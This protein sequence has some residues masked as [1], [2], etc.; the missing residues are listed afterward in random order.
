MIPDEVME[1]AERVLGY[2]E[3]HGDSP[4][5]VARWALPDLLDLARMIVGE[6][7]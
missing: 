2:W 1:E 7:A 6:A 5:V 3:I 4:E